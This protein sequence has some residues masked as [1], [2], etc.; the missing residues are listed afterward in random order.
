MQFTIGQRWISHTET[1]LGLGI[2]TEISTRRVKIIFPAINESRIYAIESAPLSRITYNVGDHISNDQDLVICVEQITHEDGLYSYVG[3]DE[4]G[5]QHTLH[6]LDLSSFVQF[7]TPEQRLFSNQIDKNKNF[8]LRIETLKHLHRLQQSKVKGLLGCRTDLLPHQIFIAHK[9]ANRHAPRVLLADEVGLGKTIEAGMILHFQHVT[10]QAK[11]I[12]IL[13]PDSLIHQWLVEMLRR[14]NLSFSVFDHERISA[15]L[16]EGIKQPFDSEQ[17]ILS[18]LNLFI[19]NPEYREYLNSSAWDTVVIDEAH[20]L[21]WSQLHIS[22]EYQLVDDLAAHCKSLLLITATPEQIGVESHFA[23][24]RL[25]DP[26]RFHDFASYQQEQDH[27]QQLNHYLVQLQEGSITPEDPQLSAMLPSGECLDHQQAITQLLDLHGTGRV[28]FR[29]T[30]NTVASFPQRRVHAYALPVAEDYQID[31]TKQYPETDFDEQIWLQKDPRVTWL[32]RLLDGLKPEKV[33]VICHHASSAIQLDNFLNLRAGIRSTSFYE[34]MTIIERDRAA[35]YFAEGADTEAMYSDM[36]AQVMIC[37]EIGSEGRNFQFASHLVLFDL[38]FNPD[39]IEQRI[40]RLDR[41]GQKKDI[42]IHLPYLQDTAQEILFHWLNDGL[43]LFANNCSANQKILAQ[44]EQPLQ[45]Q[46]EQLKSSGKI[47]KTTLSELIQE[48]HTLTQT[49][50]EELQQGRDRLIELNS[51]DAEQAKQLIE[52]INAASHDQLLLDYM[53]KVFD[54]LGVISEFH[55]DDSYIIKPS[56][57]MHSELTGLQA[58]ACTITFSRSKALSR[59]DM[60]YMTWEHPLVSECLEMIASSE[61]GNTAV[62]MISTSALAKGS[63]LIETWYSLNVIAEERLQLQRYLPCTPTRCLL[64]NKGKDYSQAISYEILNPLCQSLPKK[65]ALA[66]I[67]KTKNLLAELLQKSNHILDTQLSQIKLQAIELM[68]QELGS[69][70]NRL[71]SLQKINQSVRDDEIVFLQECIDQ[72]E[73]HIKRAN[74][75]L[76]AVR[77]IVNN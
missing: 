43:K 21:A 69:E 39:L 6:E 64:D 52:Q 62:A 76:Q 4:N 47:D 11:R 7:S 44:F 71:H 16:N 5:H 74:F 60:E 56:E 1:Q 59:E 12:L 28:Y 3:T 63:L 32:L 35:A 58:E 49:L 22:P 33:L 72:S 46:I 29:N 45:Q 38:T 50:K 42:N 73:Q 8:S 26:A 57:N 66:I 24:L 2:V 14:F 36:A 41:I 13:V 34:G 70:L 15:L 31:R 37:S 75:Q 23:R 40:G 10:Q 30:R 9:I 53:D 17:L 55:S 27:Y 77:I 18:S 68:Q 67:Q 65:T 54:Q 48:T 19:E 20:H 25:L 51:F 61:F